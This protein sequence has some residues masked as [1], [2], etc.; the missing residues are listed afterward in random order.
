MVILGE[1][2][3][4]NQ[5]P[6]RQQT[7]IPRYLACFRPLC[8]CPLR[9]HGMAMTVILVGSG[10]SV[11]GSWPEQWWGQTLNCAWPC[12]PT[13]ATTQRPQQWKWKAVGPTLDWLKAPI[14]E[15]TN[16]RG[17]MPTHINSDLDLART[18]TNYNN[19]HKPTYGGPISSIFFFS[20]TGFFLKGW[21]KMM[22]NKRP[23]RPTIKMR[24]LW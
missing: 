2:Q 6:L 18:S 20:P 21:L 13:T 8:R 9:R 22:S 17:A 16:A 23:K 7:T 12:W 14:G 11:P 19:R 15:G 24:D 4:K 5:G 10:L 1:N 3:V